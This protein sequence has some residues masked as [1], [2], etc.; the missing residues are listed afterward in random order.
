ME[1]EHFFLHADD[2]DIVNKIYAKVYD[3]VNLQG[4]TFRCT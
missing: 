2:Y 3:L 1:S 4:C